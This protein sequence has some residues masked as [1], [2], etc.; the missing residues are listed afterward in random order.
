MKT[1]GYMLKYNYW[2]LVVLCV[3]VAIFFQIDC[4]KKQA[5]PTSY[6][7]F[8]FNKSTANTLIEQE[9]SAAYDLLYSQKFIDA[10]NSYST[11]VQKDQL[12]GEAHLGLSLALRYLGKLSDAM[13]E[14]QQALTI[15]SS[16]VGVLLN[17]ADLLSPFRGAKL[18]EN[19]SDSVRYALAE[20]YYK[21]GLDSKHPLSAYGHIG[22]W[23]IYFIGQ[24][25]LN[26]SRKQMQ[27]LGRK[28]Y[29]PA[30]LL[31]FA[32]N[33]LITA[34]PDAII[35]TNGDNDTYPL[36][37]LQES[38]NI[39]KDVSVVNIN[40]L[41]VPKVAIMMR[42]SLKV[43]ISFTD[44]E[45]IKMKPVKDRKG[46]WVY[47]AD[48]LIANIV[49]NARKFKRPVYFTVTVDRNRIPYY[50]NFFITE[51]LLM[52]VAMNKTQDSIDVSKV[53]Q[54]LN[55]NY[56]LKNISKK[57]VWISNLSPMTRAYQHLS[58][59]Y[60]A[61][62]NQLAQYYEKTGDKKEAVKY[63]KWTCNIIGQTGEAGWLE[64]IQNKI[65]E[66]EQ[67]N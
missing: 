3:V 6:L 9:L 24:G 23:N 46:F 21:K 61:I 54:N 15:D 4:R 34:E 56:R 42:D 18:K 5:Y 53:I 20:Y 41:N 31:D 13:I 27:E 40:L 44:D 67:T 16:S 17:Y 30:G 37:C 63:Y 55:K 50:T 45:I 48:N 57:D 52:R 51:G 58:V 38:E 39:R 35:F 26:Q 28:K 2:R 43:P 22:L 25:Q 47:P 8:G 62:A 7:R 49:E 65:K 59:N 60:V 33:M 19:L 11:V 64:P 12:N 1:G 66:L 10:K 36:L 29:Y 14:C 32:Y